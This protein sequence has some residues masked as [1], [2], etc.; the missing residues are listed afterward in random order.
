M[1]CVVLV[2]VQI[3]VGGFEFFCLEQVVIGQNCYY[4][5][6]QMVIDQVGI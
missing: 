2:Q 5:N 6:C 4:V 3:W 1:Y